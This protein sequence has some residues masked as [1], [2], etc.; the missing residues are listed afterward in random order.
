MKRIILSLMLLAMG[1]GAM[2]QIDFGPRVNLTST[3]LSL[4][5]NIQAVE[6]GDAQ[7]GY[8]LGAFL[9]VQVPVVGIYVQPEVLF[10]NPNSSVNVNSE[11]LDFDFN[12]IDVPVMIGFKLGPVRLNA[13]PSFRFLTG[14]EVTNPNGIVE[15]VKENYKNATV[16]YQAG[17]GID[18]WKLV[19]DLKYE[20]S[21]SDINEDIALPPNHGGQVIDKRINQWVF[22]VGFKIF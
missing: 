9:R 21:L 13:G 14:A 11:K 10:S 19:F 22:G 18:I 3:N 16:G 7:F 6:E 20:G 12:Q 17:A 5:E 8:Q 15:D 2:A 4:S 1:Y